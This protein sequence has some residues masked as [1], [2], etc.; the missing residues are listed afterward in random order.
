MAL[1]HQAHREDEVQLNLS[2]QKEAREAHTLNNVTNN[3]YS[4][5]SS[6]RQ[7]TSPCSKGT[8]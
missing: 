4:V 3:L 6:C 5:L 7:A 2:L 1:G 8:S